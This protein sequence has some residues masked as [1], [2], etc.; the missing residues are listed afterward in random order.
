MTFFPTIL[1]QI[2]VSRLIPWKG[3][4]E[5]EKERVNRRKGRKKSFLNTFLTS[6]SHHDI[7]MFHTLWA[8]LNDCIC[9]A[10]VWVSGDWSMKGRQHPWQE[11]YAWIH[12]LFSMTCG[13]PSQN[14][15]KPSGSHPSFL[16]GSLRTYL[17]LSCKSCFSLTFPWP[18]FG[19]FEHWRSKHDMQNNC[20]E[21]F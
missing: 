16:H 4:G 2:I 14:R 15:W 19:T 9:L 7:G 8:V 6:R 21:T 18:W 20:L 5:K 11:E 10:E 1:F 13:H 12:D 3:L 17:P